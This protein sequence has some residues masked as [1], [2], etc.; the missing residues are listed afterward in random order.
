MLEKNESLETNLIARDF[1][2]ETYLNLVFL[3]ALKNVYIN[4]DK[5]ENLVNPLMSI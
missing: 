2:K 4:S 5:K 1:I 3:I